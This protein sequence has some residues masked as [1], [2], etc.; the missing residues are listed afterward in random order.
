[1]GQNDVKPD[2][3]IRHASARGPAPVHLWNPPYCGEIDIRID[4][5]GTWFHE[6]TPI[7]RQAMVRLFASILKR[8]ADRY[9]L[10]TPVEKVGITVEDTPFIAVDCD[11]EPEGVSFLTNMDERV[12]AGPDHPIRM[13]DAPYVMIRGGMEARIDRKTFYRL[14]ELAEERGGVHGIASG[15]MFF[16]IHP[17]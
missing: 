11:V 12:I 9:F 1:M 6:G 16:A 2:T 8:E 15:G 13:G 3:L 5:G 10:V 4:K 17:G 14:V 7:G